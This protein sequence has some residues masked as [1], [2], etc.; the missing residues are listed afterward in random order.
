MTTLLFLCISCAAFAQ[1][2]QSNLNT[3]DITN[4][5]IAYDQICASRDSTRQYELLNSFFLEKG[6]PG[7][8]AIMQAR[9]YTAKSY[10]DAIN[11]YPLFWNSIRPNTLKAVG[12]A[13]KIEIALGR[14]KKLY[15]ALKPSKIYFTIG[16]LRTGGT[17]QDGMVLIGSEIAMA[18]SSTVSSEFPS[19]LKHLRP[20]FN[21][22]PVRNVVFTNVHEYVHTQQKTTIAENLLG[23]SV[24]EGVAEFLAVK[25][26]AQPS[27]IPAMAYGRANEENVKRRF[28]QQ[29]FNSFTGFWLYSNAEN[30]FNMRDLGYYVG[31]TICERY[32]NQAADKAKAMQDMVELDYNNEAELAD[33]VDKSAYFAQPMNALHELFESSRPIVTSISPLKNGDTLVSPNVTTITLTFSEPMDTRYRN[34]ESGSLGES[35]LMQVQKILGF[36][37]DSKSLSLEVALKP[38]QQYQLIIGPGFRSL[39]GIALKPYQINFKTG[40]K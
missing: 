19:S 7:L 31:Y 14:L 40:D 17:T 30:E 29:M 36:S 5:W 4:F 32:Y 11:N 26:T 8:K 13:K 12:M 10:I 22:N 16:A 6:T 20:F 21:S 35:K 39:W 23:Q 15:P 18:D 2:R 34:F 28:A 33:F 24:L 9:D 27:T 37:A 3:S 38:I 25:A 1:H